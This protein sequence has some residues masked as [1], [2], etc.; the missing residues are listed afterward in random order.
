M[1]G[2]KR[3]THSGRFA[4]VKKV[5]RFASSLKTRKLCHGTFSLLNLF[6]SSFVNFSYC[7]LFFGAVAALN[8]CGKEET[9]QSPPQSSAL[10]GSWIST[11]AADSSGEKI[12]NQV[13]VTFSESSFESTKST[14]TA[15]GCA[16]DAL[17]YGDRTT[18]T[19]SVSGENVDMKSIDRLSRPSTDKSVELFKG[20]CPNVSFEKG[21]ETSMQGCPVFISNLGKTVY[22]SF[23]I[24]G[25]VLRFA[26]RDTT[27]VTT[28]G[29]TPEKRLKK[30]QVEGYTRVQ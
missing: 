8:A 12:W 27:D 2:V 29:S 11:C 13:K 6:R 9:S 15:A 26:V 18:G 4:S 3:H 23:G 16:A 22:T 28:D 1:S 14:F 10:T 21:K 5:S 17:D 20:I 30:R 7:L 19:Y 24:E 25:N